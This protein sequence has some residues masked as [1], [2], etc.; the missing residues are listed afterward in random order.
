MKK[1][2]T[3]IILFKLV[4]IITCLDPPRCGY[5]SIYSSHTDLEPMGEYVDWWIYVHFDG[6]GAFYTDSNLKTKE[7]KVLELPDFNMRDKT[8]SSPITNTYGQIK[9]ND[10]SS[11]AYNDNYGTSLGG[12]QDSGGNAHAK[13]FFIWNEAGG[14]HVIH[15]IPQTPQKSDHFFLD[16]SQDLYMQH[17]ICITLKKEELDVIPKYLI[18]TNPMISLMNTKIFDPQSLSKI[19]SNSLSN[20]NAININKNTVPINNIDTIKTFTEMDKIIKDNFITNSILPKEIKI[21][22]WAQLALH[23]KGNLEFTSDNS[24]DSMHYYK[25]NI[26]T[27]GEYF[28]QTAIASINS[29]IISER[30]VNF[31][32]MNNIEIIWQYIGKQYSGFSKWIS[33]TMTSDKGFPKIDNIYSI[34]YKLNYPFLKEK[35]E[36]SA[37]KDHSKLMYGISDDGSQKILCLGD[38][39]WQFVQDSRGG[40]AFCME[41]VGYLVD[42]M[43]RHV[44]WMRKGI[45]NKE[46]VK[47]GVPHSTV[48]TIIDFSW[49]SEQLSKEKLSDPM[50]FEILVSPNSLHPLSERLIEREE[51][52]FKT[53]KAPLLI[54]SDQNNNYWVEEISIDI[55]HS[56]ADK[57]FVCKQLECTYESTIKS[58]IVSKLKLEVE[59]SQDLNLQFKTPSLIISVDSLTKS[60][61]FSSRLADKIFSYAKKIPIKIYLVETELTFDDFQSD[62]YKNP[63]KTNCLFEKKDDIFSFRFH[64]KCIDQLTFCLYHNFQPEIGKKLLD[65]YNDQAIFYNHITEVLK[66]IIPTVPDNIDRCIAPPPGPSNP[67]TT[68]DTGNTMQKNSMNDMNDSDDTNDSD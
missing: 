29:K 57:V 54:S 22:Q 39:N 13:G 50:G 46:E 37:S 58:N 16:S 31:A 43:K 26:N 64:P 41:D 24:F 59:S 15:S 48:G 3:F 11:I 14:I 8:T 23:I 66:I 20:F 28:V 1:L 30:N 42:Y 12:S 10:F 34:T 51:S 2:I 56:I 6:G 60:Y 40:G 67:S 45:N 27:F 33:Q 4:T 62:F 17:S 18:Y 5:G 49:I 52:N 63:H 44:S 47:T 25:S 68:T 9:N 19:N 35:T 55:F 36:R 32:P 53:S 61:Y 21:L 38:L 7:K 65:G